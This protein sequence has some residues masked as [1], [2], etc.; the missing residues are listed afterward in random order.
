MSNIFCNFAAG[1]EKEERIY[2]SHS[3]KNNTNNTLK[4]TIM[5][6]LLLLSSLLF[7]GIITVFAQNTTIQGASISKY[8]ATQISNNGNFFIVPL[9]ADLHVMS[10]TMQ[11]HKIVEV[12]T[13]PEIKKKEQETA[14]LERIEKFL[15]NKLNELKAQALYEFIDAS[16]ASL[17]V[18]PIYSTKTLSSRGL[19]MR[20]EV[21]V[22]GY[23]A[24][25]NNFRSLKAADSTIIKLNNQI[26]QKNL[27]II[28]I[29]KKS[30]DRTE[31]TEEIIR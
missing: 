25:Y 16:G 4:N 18:S 30:T 14:Y 22:K 20:L 19:E 17:I 24:T 11:E 5:K 28:S 12:V 23:P 8:E 1:N 31:R 21:R 7:A 3:L 6:K 29:E 15:T 26:K 10:N 9:V 13:L 27:D 2:N